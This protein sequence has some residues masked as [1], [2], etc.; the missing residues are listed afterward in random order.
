MWCI[1]Q[2]YKMSVAGQQRELWEALPQKNFS[3]VWNEEIGFGDKCVVRYRVRDEGGK[4]GWMVINFLNE[5]QDM[6]VFETVATDLVWWD[7]AQKES[8][9]GRLL[10]RILDRDGKILISTLPQEVW[11]RMRIEESQDP[12]YRHVQFTTFDNERNLPSGKIQALAAGLSPEEYRMRILGEYVTLSGLCFPEF[13][14]LL[15]PDGHVQETPPEL[16]EDCRTFLFIDPGVHTAVLLLVVNEDGEKFVWDEVYTQ[17]P[18]VD[19]V[20]DRVFAMLKSW[21]LKPEQ[22]VDIAMDPQ[23]WALTPSNELT[24][25]DEYSREGI[26]ARRWLRTRDYG[27]GERAMINIVRND[28]KN[29]MLFVNDRCVNT[30]REM[31]SWRWVMDE[32]Q[33]IDIRE[34]TARTDNHACDCVKAWIAERPGFDTA[35]IGVYDTADDLDTFD[36]EDTTAWQEGLV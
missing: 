5:Q 23:G 2:T 35:V 25:A 3:R 28:L 16:P 29:N 14:N 7:E 15:R 17:G 27:G 20:C 9:F 11:L 13:T 34:R 12:R 6:N 24:L 21:K 30:I 1:A 19:A 4:S 22:L 33:K 36:D 32:R 10:L 18:R 31:R 8:L 26:H